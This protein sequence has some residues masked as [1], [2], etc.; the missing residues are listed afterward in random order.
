MHCVGLRGM[1]ALEIRLHALSSFLSEFVRRGRARSSSS[2][3]SKSGSG[4]GGYFDGRFEQ[5][6]GQ[7]PATKRRRLEEAAKLEMAR[8]VSAQS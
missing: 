3:G 6:G 7:Q 2:G 4:A 5:G 1:Q 8:W